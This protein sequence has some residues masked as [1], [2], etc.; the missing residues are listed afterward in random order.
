MVLTLGSGTGYTVGSPNTGAVTIA[1]DETP[2][3]SITATDATASEPGANTG[4]FTLTRLG[5]KSALLTVNYTVG[6][7]ATLGYD[8]VSVG[9]S[10]K[11]AAGATNA[12]VT[13][14]PVDDL[15]VEGTESVLVTL[16][17]GT[18]YTVGT[19][20]SATV[21]ITDNDPSPAPLPPE[22][23]VTTPPAVAGSTPTITITRAGAEVVLTWP[24]TTDSYVLESTPS[25]APPVRWTPLTLPPAGSQLVLPLTAPTRFFR[26]RSAG[27]P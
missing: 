11:I 13:V 17:S 26:L 24:A 22:S 7:T 3:I 20:A 25:L 23:V 12:S 18:G 19:P 8:Y 4:L 15:L 1:D 14:T 16:A 10:V 21:S 2:L 5:K 6:G 27:T 9:A